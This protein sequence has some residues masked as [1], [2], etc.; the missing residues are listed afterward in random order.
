MISENLQ[1]Q[2]AELRE[3]HKRQS[4][5]Q[6]EKIRKQEALEKRVHEQHLESLRKQ[7]ELESNLKKQHEESLA[8]QSKKNAGIAAIMNIMKKHQS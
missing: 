6:E 7:E 8:E 5:S 4:L 3:E 2:L 1:K